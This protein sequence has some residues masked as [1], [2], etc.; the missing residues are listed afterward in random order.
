MKQYVDELNPTPNKLSMRKHF[1]KNNRFDFDYPNGHETKIRQFYH[2]LPK[3]LKKSIGK[4]FAKV[5]S[6]FCKKYPETIGRIN[7]RKVFKQNFVE[8]KS[9][10][11]R[12]Y[13]VYC[14]DS[15]GRIQKN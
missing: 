1:T 2:Y 15:Q 11:Y 3:L 10:S 13:A 4:S 8:Y 5:F 14:I 6:D 12:G 9:H 7:T